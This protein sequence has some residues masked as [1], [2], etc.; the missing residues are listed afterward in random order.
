MPRLTVWVSVGVQAACL[1][2]TAPTLSLAVP[3]RVDLH[4]HSWGLSWLWPLCPARSG[5]APV[6]AA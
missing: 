2:T 4:I 6:F 5:L 1:A 3:A